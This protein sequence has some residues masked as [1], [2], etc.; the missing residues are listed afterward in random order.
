MQ[1]AKFIGEIAT[2]ERSDDETTPTPAQKRAS[3][4]GKARAKKLSRAK[5]VAIARKGG[6]ARHRKG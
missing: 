1:L 4:G 6:T 3:K 5:R 2:G